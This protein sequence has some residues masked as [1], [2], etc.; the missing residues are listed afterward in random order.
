MNQQNQ[1]QGEY[2]IG[3]FTVKTQKD[4][5]KQHYRENSKPPVTFFDWFNQRRFFWV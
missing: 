5:N 2:K 4:S 1:N 3:S